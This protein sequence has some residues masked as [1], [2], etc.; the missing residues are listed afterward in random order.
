MSPLA[1]ELVATVIAALR[2][3]PAIAADLREAL[4]LAEL[5]SSGWMCAEAAVSYIGLGS[6]DALDRLVRE[7]LPCAQPSGPGGRRLFERAAVDRWLRDA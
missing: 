6:T 7:G 1:T 4:G 3:D 5:S 2:D